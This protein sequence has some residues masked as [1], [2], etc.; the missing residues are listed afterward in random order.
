M[1]RS[2]VACAAVMPELLR[3]YRTGGGVPWSSYGSDMVEAQGDFNRPWLLASLGNEYLPAIPDVDRRLRS[4][5]PARVADVACGVGWA[6]IAIA[7]AYPNVRVDGFDLDEASIEVARTNAAKAGL[8]D[9]VAFHAV[10][11]A[12]PGAK[13][14]Y[15]LAIVVEAVHDLAQPIEVLHAIREMLCR[16]RNGDRGRREDRA[17]RSRLR[18]AR[19]SG[20]STATASPAACRQGWRS[21]PS[22]AT[23]TVMR[24]STM[25]EYARRAGFTAID[26]LDVPHDFLRFYRLTP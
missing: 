4:D 21:R 10:D 7:R 13:G 22:A 18:R 11:A 15:D 16:G 17:P 26:V 3:A 2:I 19:P 24:A 8:A 6:S 23:G 14:R 1:A 20:C 5:P 25:E 12:E 9:R